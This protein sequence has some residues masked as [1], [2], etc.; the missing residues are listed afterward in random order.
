M[1][2]YETFNNLTFQKNS[3]LHNSQI[4]Y[5]GNYNYNQKFDETLNNLETNIYEHYTNSSLN[6]YEIKN[7]IRNEFS[8]LIL[9]YQKQ[10]NSYDNIIDKKINN[11][12]ANLKGIIDSKCFDNLNQTAQMINLFMKNSNNINKNKNIQQA[13][14]IE[15]DKNNLE[16]KMNTILKNQYDNKFDVLERQINSMD[17]LLK[18]FKKTFDS[19]MLDIFKSNEIKKNY[20]EK[21]EYEIYKN[22]IDSA[23]KKMK[24]EQKNINIMKEQIEKLFEKTNE[25]TLENNER[26]TISSNEI[27]LLKNNF[28]SIDKIISEIQNKINQSQIEKIKGINFEYLKNINIYEINEMKEK[29]Q[30]LNNDVDDLYEKMKNNNNQLDFMSNKFNELEQNLD[31][32]NKDVDFLNKQNLTEKL[33]DLNNKI[34]EYSLKNKS[35]TNKMEN[36]EKIMHNEEAENNLNNNQNKNETENN[37]IINEK[38]NLF[39]LTGSR[40]Q[41]KT[42]TKSEINLNSNKNNNFNLD[43]NKLKIL[44]EIENIDIFNINKKL[45]NL[46]SD[47]KMLLSRLETYNDNFLNINDQENKLNLKLDEINKR[48]K[49]SE[50]RL[51]LLELKNFGNVNENTKEEFKEEQPFNIKKNENKIEEVKINENSGSNI[52]IKVNNIYNNENQNNIES[53]LNRNKEEEL[54]QNIMKEEKN[55]YKEAGSFE[56]NKEDKSYKDISISNLIKPILDDD[57][58]SKNNN[59]KIRDQSN[60]K[61]NDTDNYDDFDDI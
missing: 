8:E 18:A 11:A 58:N 12:E 27:N 24:E 44:Q 42:L 59:S 32:I 39:G 6:Y 1:N 16:N 17:S 36:I 22:E 21:S 20:L 13:N 57:K 2:K 26:K 47:N 61:I 7:I 38:E 3:L 46:T 60:N 33:E 37:N 10:L 30:N 52:D 5:K 41:R 34:E 15:N 4:N 25:L 40:R 51:Y 9:P 45:E 43:E 31:Y 49:E 23:I 48:I 35:I 54:I 19:N 55:N 29:I 53:D 28:N 56:L 14:I 50:N